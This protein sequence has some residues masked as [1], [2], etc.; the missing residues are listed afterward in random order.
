LC[1]NLGYCRNGSFFK[2]NTKTAVDI[3]DQKVIFEAR[4]DYWGGASAVKRLEII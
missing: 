2:F 3:I 4:E 1:W